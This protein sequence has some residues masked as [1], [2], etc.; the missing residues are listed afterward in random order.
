MNLIEQALDILN[1]NKIKGDISKWKKALPN[2][3]SYIDSIKKDGV[4]IAYKKV[5]TL[6]GKQDVEIG[7]YYHNANYGEIDFQQTR[8]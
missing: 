8:N 6:K 5:D 3:T 1:E 2:D 7:R 4:S